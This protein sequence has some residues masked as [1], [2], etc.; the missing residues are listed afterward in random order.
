MQDHFN[1][2]SDNEIDIRELLHLL[3]AF[4]LFIVGICAVSI[5]F[6]G[7]FTLKKNN[8][9]TSVAIFKL[10]EQ[11]S[12]SFQGGL[13][14]IANLAGITNTS[15]RI[16]LPDAQIKGRI[17]IENVDAKLNFLTDPY[18]NTYNPKAIDPIWKSTIKRAIGWQNFSNGNEEAIWQEISKKYAQNIKLLQTSDE[19]IKIIVTHEKAER[20]AEIANVIMQEII[21]I[22][23]NLRDKQQDK[24][25]SYLSNTLAKALSDLEVSQSNLKAFAMEETTLPKEGF[26]SESIKLERLREQ[27]SQTSDLYEAA[28]DLLLMVKNNT[29]KHADYLSLRQ[30]HPIIDLVEFRRI[31]GQNEIIGSWSWPEVS[32]VAEIHNTLSERKIRLQSQIDISLID[33]QRSGQAFETYR[34]LER[35]AKIAEATYTVLIEQVK[36]QSMTAGYRP[37]EAEIYEYASPSISP[38]SPNLKRGLLIGA[39]LGLIVG[40][41]LALVVGINRNVFYSKKSLVTAAQ[42]RINASSRTLTSLRNKSLDAIDILTQKKPWPILRDIAV[43]IHKGK[44]FLTVVTSSNAKKISYEIGLALALTIQTD[45]TKIAVI[46]F[47]KRKNPKITPDQASIGSFIV[48]E[49]TGQVSVL[50]PKSES[51]PKKIISQKDFLKNIQALNSSFNLVFL[52]ADNDDAL[53][54]LRALEGQKIFHLMLAKTKKTNSNTLQCMRSLLPIQGLLHD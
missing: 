41:A 52:C 14:A 50:R 24:H 44:N 3:S 32:T 15:E 43:E 20:A 40:S 37:T 22:N 2:T 23:S 34:Q 6:S 7:Y 54:L 28:T 39:I 47:K 36:A 29:T 25:L 17:F 16:N 18:F 49:A 4:K 10:N 48:S 21:S 12:N 53:S 11:K 38:S 35:E 30:T 51:D 27:F 8:I 1:S 45:D 31:M 26:D 19:A 13:N 5:L 46:D 42:A 33:I 9:Y